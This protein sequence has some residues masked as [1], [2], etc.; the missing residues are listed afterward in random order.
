LRTIA[1]RSEFLA[2]KR[3]VYDALIGLRLDETPAPVEE[4][5]R[6][7]EQSRSRAWRD[8]LQP[9][10]DPPLLASVQ[11]ALPPGAV[12]LEYWTGVG[13][14]AIIW[15][16]RDDKGLVARPLTSTGAA[17]IQQL[18]AAVSKRDA[19][20]RPL[21]VNAGEVL[22]AH[23]PPL[24]AARHVLIV[25]DG[26]MHAIP[27]ETLT[28]A[29]T[30][31]LLVERADVSYLPSSAF[32]VVRRPAPSPWAWPWQRELLAFGNPSAAPSPIET[33]RLPPLP[34]AD[35]ELRRIA[36]VLPGRSDLH[37]GADA[38]KAFVTGGRLRTPLL[39][40]STHAIADIRDPD[41]SRV[42]LAPESPGAPADYLFLREVNDLDL[43]GVSLVT[44]SACDTERGRIVRGEGVEGF[45]RALLAAGAAST[46]TTMWEVTDRPGAELMAAFYTA[47]AGGASKA[48]A[49][50]HA[51]LTFLRSDSA[52][53]HPYY[54][55][56]YLLSGDGD[57]PLPRV[58]PWWLVIG[59]P[60]AAL[61]AISAALR[62]AAT[63]RR[64]TI[65]RRTTG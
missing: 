40:F 36:Q 20:W 15:M 29:G 63:A 32:L 10:A 48:A 33:R 22:L 28:V 21:S 64:S 53:A 14:L 54:W 52:W 12:L 51:K 16:T 50:R 31:A 30:D 43:S 42:L 65:P 58:V 3:D 27:F 35:E 46:V 45:S 39:H 7:F 4:L 19:E 49:L 17:T 23:L 13:R 8:R 38:R 57:G 60:L 5:F 6:L 18:A 9:N 26:P 2:D 44:L 56:A 55:A 61:L 34:Y 59:A 1:L 11:A 24:P 25:A 62:A 37:T 47:A 41:R